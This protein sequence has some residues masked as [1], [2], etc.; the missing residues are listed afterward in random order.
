MTVAADGR[1]ARTDYRVLAGYDEPVPVSL[2]ELAL[3]T[4]RT[5]QIRV[6]LRSI[7]HAVVG[8]DQYGGVRE[9]F[10]VP[11]LKR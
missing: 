8:D 9:S 11:R 2:L 5:H 10:P 1:E 4:G 6:H 3:H 7:G